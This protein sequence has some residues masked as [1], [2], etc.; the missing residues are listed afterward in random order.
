MHI[1]WV[2]ASNSEHFRQSYRNIAGLL[3]LSGFDDPKTD[4]LKLV[5]LWL[6]QESNGPWLMILDNM[7]DDRFADAR[8]HTFKPQ[9]EFAI[10]KYLPQREGGSVLITS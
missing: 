8:Q 7:D 4:V 9:Y 10:R 2:N 6:C 5:Y 3:E 1:F